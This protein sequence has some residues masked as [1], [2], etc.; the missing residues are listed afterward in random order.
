MKE[1]QVQNH[2]PARYGTV[3]QAIHWATALFTC[4]APA[5]GPRWMQLAAKAVQGGLYLLLFAVPLTAIAGAWLDGHALTLLAGMQVAPPFGASNALGEKLA[6]LHTWFGD[7]R[8]VRVLVP[9]P[10]GAGGAH[11]HLCA[12]G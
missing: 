9:T 4:P 11:Q 3:A 7:A 6:E 5:P 12:A 1:T 2:S 8:P 10:A